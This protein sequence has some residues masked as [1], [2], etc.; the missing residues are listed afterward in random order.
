MKY[1]K[2]FPYPICWVKSLALLIYLGLS[3][4]VAVFWG[5]LG[6]AI[7]IQHR[8]LLLVLLLPFVFL[9]VIHHICIGAKS[10]RHWFPSWCSWRTALNAM[11]VGSLAFTLAILI[12]YPLSSEFASQTSRYHFLTQ[13]E[14][15]N[16]A[17]WYAVIALTV[18]AYLYH[19]DNLVRQ[20]RKQKKLAKQKS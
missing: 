7:G 16:D 15:D 12:F 4:R 3:L 1:P 19:Y 13:Q 17:V 5:M 20:S 14:F 9:V 18:A 10:K 8:A 2:W 11:I 6:T